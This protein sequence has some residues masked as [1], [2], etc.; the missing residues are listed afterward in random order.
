MCWRANN[1]GDINSNPE[2]ERKSADLEENGKVPPFQSDIIE[3]F[4]RQ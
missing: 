4:R 2:K 1:N 3:K